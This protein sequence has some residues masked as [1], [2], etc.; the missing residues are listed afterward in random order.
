MEL[1]P[2]HK[3]EDSANRSYRETCSH[4]VCQAEFSRPLRCP[5]RRGRS[6]DRAPAVRL[7]F[8][9]IY[10]GRMSPADRGIRAV[11]TPAPSLCS[12]D[13]V[14]VFRLP[15]RLSPFVL[16]ARN[17]HPA[18]RPQTT[19]HLPTAPTPVGGFRRP[20]LPCASTA[21]PLLSRGVVFTHFSRPEPRNPRTRD[22]PFPRSLRTSQVG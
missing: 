1:R 18:S 2:T 8:R 9:T 6:Y 7:L 16:R 12:M 22:F 5:R 14:S 11:M 21:S 10:A 13:T 15:A 4:G 20:L 17:A 19:P 3:S